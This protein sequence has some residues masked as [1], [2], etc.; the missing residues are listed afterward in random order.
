MSGNPSSLTHTYAEGSYSISAMATDDDGTY[1]AGNTITVAVNSV[2][3]TLTLS[4]AGTVNE[5]AAYTL[6]LSAIQPSQDPITNW[7]INWGDGVTQTVSGNPSSLTHT[8]AEGSYTISATATDDDGT[9]SAG[10]TIAVTANSVPP[11]I[12]LSGPAAVNELSAY[13]L[14][15]S[16]IEPSQD[17]ITSWTINWGDGTT[18]T[19]NGNPSTVTHTYAEGNYSISAKATDDDGTYTRRQYHRGGRQQRAPLRS[20]SV[21]CRL[22]SRSVALQPSTSWR[23]TRY[24]Y[25][26]SNPAR[27]PSRAGPSTGAMVR[28]RP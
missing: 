20:P 14:S 27:M 2:P 4:G 28:P 11:T 22:L 7:T 25:R 17:A 26:R 13:T 9:Y 19:V 8:Y 24:P 5:L 18:Q 6:S 1:K 10:N 3:P 16:A 21:A 23:H 15:L 12:T